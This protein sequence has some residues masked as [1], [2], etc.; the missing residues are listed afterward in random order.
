MTQ[1]VSCI[2]ERVRPRRHAPFTRHLAFWIRP[3]LTAAVRAWTIRRDERILEA[4]PDHELKDIGIG[5][6]DIARAVRQGWPP[7]GAA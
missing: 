5:R 2:D 3:L 1:A 4:M 6:G 7:T